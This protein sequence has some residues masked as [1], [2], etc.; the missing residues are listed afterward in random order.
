MVCG[1]G[2][3]AV[4]WK[5]AC[6]VRLS[7]WVVAW[8]GARS[9]HGANASHRVSS[10]RPEL[11][12]CS[13]A[14]HKAGAHE[15]AHHTLA[16][17]STNTAATQ[18]LPPA[19]TVHWA[20]GGTGDAWGSRERRGGGRDGWRTTAAPHSAALARWRRRPGTAAEGRGCA[21]TP[22]RSICR[23]SARI[24]RPSA[25]CHACPQ[26]GSG[27]ACVRSTGRSPAREESC[28]GR[29]CM[30]CVMRRRATLP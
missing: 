1:L 3:D 2:I 11:R 9:G 26:R 5:T 30:R 17:V 7:G 24:R 8:G 4:L 23:S 25:P 19:A 27:E 15:R 13:L 10:P 28:S 18:R 21:C 6:E 29:W 20:L 16:V 12:C 14:R 22:R